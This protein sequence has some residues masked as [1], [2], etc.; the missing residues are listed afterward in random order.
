MR[1]YNVQDSLLDIRFCF[2]IWYKIVRVTL[3]HIQYLFFHHINCPVLAVHQDCF[4]DM[5]DAVVFKHWL[6]HNSVSHRLFS[7]MYF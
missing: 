6:Y 1:L 3:Q 4:P 2:F 5:P 7:S